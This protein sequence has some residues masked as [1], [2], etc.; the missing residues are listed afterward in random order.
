MKRLTCIVLTISSL[1]GCASAEKRRLAESEFDSDI[2]LIAAFAEKNLV[3]LDCNNLEIPNKYLKGHSFHAKEC[4]LL[5]DQLFLNGKLK[6]E[7]CPPMGL[8]GKECS[9]LVVKTMMAKTFAR[10][11]FATPNKLSQI[12]AVDP[13]ACSDTRKTETIMLENNNDN[14]Q[15]Q[16]MKNIDAASDRY[17]KKQKEIDESGPNW[18]AAFGALGSGMQN[19][20]SSQQS[21]VN[22]TSY[23]PA[24]CVGLAPLP[25]YNCRSACI[26]GQWSSV[27]N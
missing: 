1:I 22:P 6:G 16:F 25:Q 11:P 12:C 18:A 3:S 19:A 4:G 17:A 5:T 7:I 10:Y 20:S 14:I 24:Q 27:C 21:S 9:D 13:V 2:T 8:K 15:L 26:N 23:H